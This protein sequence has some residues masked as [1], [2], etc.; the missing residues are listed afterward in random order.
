MLPT[1]SMSSE[2]L[3]VEA[4]VGVV[5][6]QHALE[7]GVVTLDGKHGVVNDLADGRLLGIGFEMGPARL[8]GHPKYVN[9]PVLVRVFRVSSLGAVRFE[10]GV[11]FFEGV[12]DVFQENQTEHD[13][14]VLGGVHVG[15]QRVGGTPELG[16]ETEIRAIA[17][18][19]CHLYKSSSSIH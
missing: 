2:P 4:R 19:F 7:R 11:L 12:G 8:L 13:V 14:L 1:M 9:G 17:M 5:L 15:A 18:V 10:L 3:L 16:F 6:G